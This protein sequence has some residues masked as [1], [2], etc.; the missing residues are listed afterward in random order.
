MGI[1]IIAE[2]FKYILTS[3]RNATCKNSINAI[4]IFMHLANMSDKQKSKNS[5]SPS[6]F[7]YSGSGHGKLV[8][9]DHMSNQTKFYYSVSFARQPKVSCKPSGYK[10]IFMFNTT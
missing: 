9:V 2:T 5:N 6:A 7:E 8:S 1:K 10:I 4:K 3:K